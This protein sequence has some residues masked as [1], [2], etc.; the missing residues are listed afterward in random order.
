MQY[1]IE[2]TAFS[3]QTRQIKRGTVYDVYFYIWTPDGHKHQKRLCGFDSTT[4][5]KK[6]HT[7]WITEHCTVIERGT[8]HK[9]ADNA[10]RKV[11]VAVAA[12]GFI[13]SL[14]NKAA[15][16]GIYDKQATYKDFVLPDLG[17]K[18]VSALTVDTIKAWQNTLWTKR[19]PR[20]GEY[21]S[22]NYLSKIRANT[23]ALLSY[24]E[25]VYGIPNALHKIKKPARVKPKEPMKYWTR[26]QFHQFID[27]V[28]EPI[29]HTFFMTLFYTGRRK[30]EV[31]AL[32]PDDVKED[33]ILFNK[34]IS[35][36]NMDGSTYKVA[37]TKN[38][39]T[40]ETFICATL[41]RELDTYTPGSPYFFGGERPLPTTT[42]T[43]KFKEWIEKAGLP[44]IRIH[45]LRH[46]FVSMCFSLGAN[47]TVI[48]DLI[49][50]TIEQ[51]THTYAHM[52]VADKKA[53][54]DRIN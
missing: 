33:R 37:G 24:I 35:T 3:I 54:I 13:A 17:T 39:K 11:T 10:H 36:K 21:Y 15:D 49:G 51:V 14:G 12:R 6:A 5:A 1:Y 20:T 18:D 47:V 7:K 19:N 29:Y 25:D 34:A 16:G 4:K 52:Y 38:K 40:G 9:A 2:S 23:S 22:Y 28:D 46:S 41:K 27:V 48:A 50:D 30:G 32:T 53:V 42:I 31:M 43:R 8:F 45:D 26:E 44:E